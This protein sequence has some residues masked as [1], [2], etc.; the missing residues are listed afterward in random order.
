MTSRIS[1]TLLAITLVSTAVWSARERPVA[2]SPGSGGGVRLVADACTTFSWSGIEGEKRL[3]L[4]VYEVTDDGQLGRRVV[5]QSL[6]PGAS[7]WTLPAGRCLARGTTYAWTV[8]ATGKN[9]GENWSDAVVFRIIP[10]PSDAELEEALAVVR[11][12]L[13]RIGSE[14]S[15]SEARIGE[16]NEKRATPTPMLKP[17][18]GTPSAAPAATQ[19][20]VEGNVDATT[21]TGDGSNLAGVATDSEL[22]TH[23][24]DASAH[25]PPTIDTTCN[26]AACDGTSF[27]NV[28]AAAGDSASGFFSSGQIEE[29]RIDDAIAR[30]SELA[31]IASGW[32]LTGNAGTTPPTNFLGT[33]DPQ[34]L[35]LRANDTTLLRLAVDTE[36]FADQTGAP[37]LPIPDN[38]PTGVTDSIVVEDRGVVVD[39]VVTLH[40]ENSDLTTILVELTDP[41]LNVYTLF[42]GGSA[43]TVLETS[44][45][46][47]TAPVSGD[48]TSW[49]GRN[50]AGTWQ[51]EIVDSGFLDNTVDGQLVS[52]SI[53]TETLSD[54]NVAIA[55]RLAVQGD[56]TAQSVTA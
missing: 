51:L 32:S 40:L 31:S 16:A 24:L 14:E 44:F 48:L 12:H 49:I 6:P 20:S 25:H 9:G 15:V 19:M 41:D 36:S 50:P 56:V 45:P 4:N 37:N 47:P 3:R 53:E 52:W 46:T 26:G 54:P 43:G 27:S 33:T 8:G 2:V 42:S 28:T 29:A 11:R 22:S 35:E 10:G 13:A 17:L 38:N 1:R 39:L 30:D 55:S 21:F 7:S 18:K 34:P 23:S 5:G